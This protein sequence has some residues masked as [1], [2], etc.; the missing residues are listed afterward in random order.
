MRNKGDGDGRQLSLQ[1][2]FDY[3]SVTQGEYWSRVSHW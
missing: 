3:S 1:V 2:L